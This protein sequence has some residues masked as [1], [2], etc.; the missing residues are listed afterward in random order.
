MKFS[1]TPTNEILDS[2]RDRLVAEFRSL[3]DRDDI[4]RWHLKMNPHERLYV[5]VHE[6]FR[7]LEKQRLKEACRGR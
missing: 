1:A 2:E 6:Q 5:A 7:Y 3:H 4:Y